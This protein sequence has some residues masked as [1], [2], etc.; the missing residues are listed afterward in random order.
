MGYLNA[1]PSTRRAVKPEVSGKKEKNLKKIF[2]KVFLQNPYFV[3][4]I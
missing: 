4:D 1:S 3:F 2:L